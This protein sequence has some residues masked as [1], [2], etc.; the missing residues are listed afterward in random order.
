M[1]GV[2][3]S[4]KRKSE[5]STGRVFR[6]LNAIGLQYA[7][8]NFEAAGIITSEAL[9][10]LPTAVFPGLGVTDPDD[11][12]KLFY[13]V[14]SLQLA[15]QSTNGSSPS[16]EE[17]G[18][19]AARNTPSKKG[20]SESFVPQIPSP[21]RVAGEK[22]TGVAAN[23]T[24]KPAEQ[25]MSRSSS[26]ASAEEALKAENIVAS[27]GGLENENDFGHETDEGG[28][29]N[30]SDESEVDTD[31]FEDA[32][33]EDEIMESLAPRRSRRLQEQK[34]TVP[35]ARNN[36]KMPAGS[37]PLHTTTATNRRI[38]RLSTP[39][40]H[41][42]A[43]A[44]TNVKTQPL[45]PRMLPPTTEAA[46]R[47]D[48][49]E[50]VVQPA[51]SQESVESVTA[52]APPR[53]DSFQSQIQALRQGHI[54]EHDLFAPKDADK[55]PA[56][57][58]NMRIRVV[59]RKRP[60]STAEVAMAG[61]VDVLQP[62][63]YQ[64]FGKVMVY[65]PRTRV[66]LTKEVETIP[67]AFDNVFDENANNAHIYERVVRPLIP[68]LFDGQWATLF[69]FGQT[70]SGKTFVSGSRRVMETCILSR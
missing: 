6:L 53:N 7:W 64:S 38:S 44:R 67:F 52:T 66:D 40:K 51:P 16:A 62:L 47:S 49:P 43:P 70:G 39:K 9:C 32:L 8:P 55:E 25:G 57:A 37:A 11:K 33:E 29:D 65:Q 18:T 46:N 31:D 24:S 23:D 41:S 69:A 22:Q 13:L 56:V 1:S 21:A 34:D 27:P 30:G 50:K 28:D 68:G 35:T 45:V 10:E 60:M 15:K 20:S 19:P 48:I 5:S 54:E 17:R 42:A 36:K 61:N 4:P 12:R 2:A 59:I 3:A 58:G 26:Y 14:Q 63:D